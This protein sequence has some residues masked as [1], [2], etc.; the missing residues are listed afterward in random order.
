MM[1]F[2]NA[3]R[4]IV[5]ALMGAALLSACAVGPDYKRPN[6]DVPKS[7]STKSPNANASVEAVQWLSW[8]KS[9]NDPVLNQLLEEALANNQDLQVAIARIDDAKATAGIALIKSFSYC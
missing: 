6:L 1:R 4:A 2:T 7:L 9:F 5:V 3:P 8:W